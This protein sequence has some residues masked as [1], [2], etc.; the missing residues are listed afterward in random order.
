VAPHGRYIAT[1][2]G[3]S[4]VIN[5]ALSLLAAWLV[6]HTRTAIGATGVGGYAV[7]FLPQT[8]MV[9]FMSTLVPT[10]LTRRRVRS[11][12]LAKSPRSG[13]PLPHNVFLRALAIALTATL[14]IGVACML[15]SRQWNAPLQFDALLI[16]KVVYGVLLSIP[17]TRFVL[18]AALAG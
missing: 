2:T 12:Q 5:A 13:L 18:R 9:T 7:D 10:W 15:V 11:G 17:I 14:V 6:F 1:E 4:A 16:L 3:I 8:F